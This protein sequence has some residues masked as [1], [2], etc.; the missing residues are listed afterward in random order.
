MLMGEWAILVFLDWLLGR[1]GFGLP[2]YGLP[3]TPWT[4]TFVVVYVLEWVCWFI[5]PIITMLWW[6]A[7]AKKHPELLEEL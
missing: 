4:S 2:G 3:G 5:I 7:W 6:R 1:P